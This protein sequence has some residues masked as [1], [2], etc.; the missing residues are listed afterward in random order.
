MDAQPPHLPLDPRQRAMLQEMGVRLW[1]PG[2]GT[3]G[4]T[5]AAPPAARPK[6]A[7]QNP[8]TEEPHSNA[9]P[10]SVAQPTATPSPAATTT[11]ALATPTGTAA[12][13]HALLRP[14][15][16]LYPDADP[17]Q[18]PPALGNAWL[19]VA[20]G[21]DLRARLGRVDGHATLV[22]AP[23]EVRARIAPFPPEPA[24]VAALSA[25]LRARFDPRG[26]LNPG[27]MG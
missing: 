9:T 26:I 15:R 25:G 18:C 12:A 6:T 19:L 17:A 14:P 3:S 21:D 24:P 13:E 22:R 1:L 8:A 10:P 11:A 7:P 4:D 5:P 27:L 16:A 2:D 20:E 23:A